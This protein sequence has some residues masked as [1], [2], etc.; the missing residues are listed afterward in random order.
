MP[1]SL[2]PA[3]STAL[4]QPLTFPVISNLMA[5]SKMTKADLVKRIQEYGENPPTRWNKPELICRLEELMKMQGEDKATLKLQS[6]DSLKSQ[7]TELN[8]ARKKKADLTVHLQNNLGLS[9]GPNETVDQMMTRGVQAIYKQVAATSQDVVGFGR[10]SQITYGELLNNYPTYA[11]WVQQ[12][13]LEADDPD[14]RLM[15]LAAWI[16]QATHV[17]MTPTE[18]EIK[19]KGYHLDEPI[20]EPAAVAP[21]T[22]SSTAS[23]SQEQ[24]SDLKDE[25]RRAEDQE[26]DDGS[27]VQGRLVPVRHKLVDFS[28]KAWHGTCPW[29]GERYT[30]TAYTSRREE[31]LEAQERRELRDLG[32]PLKPQPI[33]EQAQVVQAEASQPNQDEAS[34]PSL[35]RSQQNEDEKIRKKLYLLHAATGHGSNKHLVEALRRRGVSERVLQLAREFKCSVCLE[36]QRAGSRPVSTLEPLPPKLS[37]ISADVGHWAHPSSGEVSQ[38]LMV[39]DEGSRFR[40]AKVL[41]KGSKQTP[42]ASLCLGF[43]QEGWIQYFGVPRVL[44]LDPAGPFR[45]HALEHFCDKQGIHLDLIPGEAHHQ[46]GVCEQAVGSIKELMTKVCVH[47]PY[48]TAEEALALGVTVCNQRE[49]IRGFSPAQHVLGQ[50][51]DTLGRLVGNELPPDLLIENAAGEFQRA[52]ARRAEAEKALVD[53]STRQRVVRAQNSRSKP[54]YD[55]E[56]G[57]LVFFWRVQ[58][59]T[60]GRRQPGNKHGAFLGPARVLATETRKDES[61]CLRPGSAIWC[62]RGRSLLKCSPEQLRR[63]SSKE[64]LVESLAEG[65][66][67]TPWT[68]TRVAEEIGGNK[69]LDISAERPTAAEWQRAQDLEQEEPPVRH[70]VRRKRPEPETAEDM[71]DEPPSQ[72]SMPSRPR[73]HGGRQLGNWCAENTGSKWWSEVPEAAW[74]AEEVSFWAQDGAAVEVAI[75]MPES[76]RGWQEAAK[77]LTSYFV[78]AL[79]RRAVE[80]SEKHLS[81]EDR[82]RFK[83]AK[84]IE[85]KNFIVSGA[86]EALPEGLRPTRDQAIGMRWILTWKHRDDGTTKAKARAVLLG[87]QDPGYEHRDTTAPVMSRQTRQLF[88]QLA[89]NK[90]WSVSKGDVSGA[91]LQGRE[92]PTQLYCVPC[93]EIC[94]AMRIPH[95]SITRLRRACYGLVDAPLEWYRT[96]S[97]YFASLGLERL[98]SDACA[99]VWRPKGQI[100]AMITGH[101]DDFLFGGS[102]QDQE[103]QELIVQ[104]KKKFK[105]GDWDLDNFTQCGVQIQRTSTGFELSQPSYLDGMVEISV[106]AARKKESSSPTTDREKSKLRALLGGL[107]WHAQQVAPHTAAEVSLLLSEVNQS[108]VN[109]IAKA[110]QLF[111]NTKARKDHRMMIHAFSEDEPLALYAWVDAATDNRPDGSSTQGIFVGVG[112]ES[113]LQGSLGGISPVAWH[114]SKIDRACRS[115]GSAETQAAVNGEDALFF[116][117]FQWSEMLYGIQDLRAHEEVARRVP[118][119]LI[120]DSRNVYD[121]LA[122]EV[123]VVKGKEKRSNIELLSIKQSQYATGLHVRWVHSEAQLANALTKVGNARELELFYRMSHQWKIVE[124]DFMRSARKR[125]EQGLKPLEGQSGDVNT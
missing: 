58:S 36:K 125:R 83:E 2:S 81:E 98:W 60:Q 97:E 62:V 101:V 82:A 26:R 77:D 53:W 44:R 29:Q 91:F 38:F 31:R 21:P 122:T 34:R 104:I 59:S 33:Q 20:P 116:A 67:A 39:I 89:A 75:S 56:P 5:T 25:K 111:W 84:S 121:K 22:P 57:E 68:F 118:G 4:L 45:S 120:T 115:P 94:D 27:Q 48:V 90:K 24:V 95:G 35:S 18:P 102:S 66:Q 92:Y 109:T 47:D 8:K 85:V 69:Y 50:S 32:F 86:F 17:K 9:V 49:L 42:N 12:T 46:I 7:I 78:G 61:G 65:Q 106:P 108:T 28:P 74:A 80:V 107:S 119:C 1:S 99:W 41:T 87:Y 10:H 16:N 55:Y 64:E 11:N 72:P 54:A 23:G 15:R 19:K 110:N 70:R 43:L 88:L 103:W 113:L 76:A 73:F 124:D 117:R 96:V 37:T 112:P 105:W 52:Q 63:A 71:D 40:A 6:K 30:I 123:V 100:R 114:S 93:D 51:P 14:P 13:A 3:T 79:K